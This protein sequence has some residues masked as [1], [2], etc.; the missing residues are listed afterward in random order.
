MPGLAAVTIP[1][2]FLHVCF[3]LERTVSVEVGCWCDAGPGHHREPGV[4]ILGFLPGAELGTD[5]E[6]IRSATLGG[7]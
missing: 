7:C 2:S 5:S 6:G 1:W 3:A 4:R